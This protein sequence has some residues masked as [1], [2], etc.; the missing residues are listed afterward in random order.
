M[1]RGLL[2][3]PL[4]G[5]GQY[6]SCFSQLNQRKIMAVLLTCSCSCSGEFH[7]IF[8][9]KICQV[10]TEDDRDLGTHCHAFLYFVLVLV[11]VDNAVSVE[12][13]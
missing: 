3:K 10:L 6:C 7:L 12:Y 13:P 8:F 9:L 4:L 1:Q 11:S 5:V 2:I